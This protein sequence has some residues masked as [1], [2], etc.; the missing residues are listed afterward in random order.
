M[1][2]CATEGAAEV[3]APR[4]AGLTISADGSY[5]ARLVRHGEGAGNWYPERWTLCGPEPYA[6]PLPGVQPEEPDS[7]LLPLT[8]GR[9]LILR[10]VVDRFAISLLYPTGG[11]GG[12]PNTGELPLGFVRAPRLRLLPPAPD[13]VSAYALA[14]GENSSTLW[15]L[16]GGDFGPELITEVPGRCSGGAWLDRGGRLL[17]VDREAAGRTKSVAVDLERGGE[18]SALLQITEESNDR[19]L[20]AD[21]DSGLLL[22]RSDAPGHD[23]LGWGVLG[24]SLPVRFPECLRPA[25]AAATPFAVQPGQMLTPENCE[26]AFRIDAATGTCLGVWRPAGRQLRRF[27]A[28]VG[29]LTG[30]G[31]WTA[32]GELRLPVDTG[33]VPCG[34]VRTAIPPEPVP[35]RANV[36]RAAPPG[37]AAN[38]PV[39]APPE[40]RGREPLRQEP[41]GPGPFGPEPPGREPY[42][43]E[44]FGPEPPGREP[45]AQESFPQE[46]FPQ[47][48][49]PQESFPRGAFP[50]KALPQEPFGVPTQPRTCRPVPLQQAPLAARDSG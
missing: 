11:A 32:G 30:S 50:Q 28:P 4:P 20:L 39:A 34:V 33:V 37:A 48:S 45:F 13:G 41:F 17:A 10:R 14:P 18:V 42:A 29:W 26:V 16:H 40:Q 3:G 15:R 35:R 46:S 44:A 12:G 19:L 8:D 6:V 22:V 43:R 5:A 1:T 27:P 24:S 25:G 38:R 21:P 49:F 47:G 2:A 9:V 36:P 31:L 23:R 7:Q